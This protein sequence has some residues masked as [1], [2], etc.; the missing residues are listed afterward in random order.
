[1][2]WKR[3]RTEGV[4]SREVEGEALVLD[5]QSQRIHQMNATA[6]FIW[7]HC[8]RVESAEG[9]ATM[10]AS[11]FDIDEATALRDVVRT[12]AELHALELL[13]DD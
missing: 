10:L 12:V 9:L 1:M 11:A 13:E 8:E 6:L 3:R 5:T 2:P 4:I 7:T